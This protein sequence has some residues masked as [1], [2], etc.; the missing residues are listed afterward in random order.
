MA[1][2]DSKKLDFLW[3]KII[4][5]AA[6]TDTINK[7]GPNEAIRA[8]VII[9][10]ENV[11]MRSKGITE[12]PPAADTDDVQVRVGS[13]SVYCVP[14]PSVPGKKT[15]ITVYDRLT[16]PMV[17]S[18]RVKNWIPPSFGNAYQPRIYANVIAADNRLNPLTENEEW[19]F[20]FKAGVIHF[21]NELPAIVADT[22]VVEGYRYVGPDGAGSISGI[23]ERK[24]TYSTPVL[25]PDEKYDFEL[26]TGYSAMILNLSVNRPSV[27][28][29]H[30]YSP[31]EDINP[32]RF[33]AVNGFLTDDGSYISEARRFY[34]PRFVYIHNLEDN[35]S[36]RTYWRIRNTG[37][38]SSSITMDAT[39]L[40]I[41]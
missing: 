14:D 10:G 20:D 41:L 38:S 23:E 30:S 34:G 33:I 31:R 35:M 28:E 6:T 24:I 39:F 12:A 21:P 15:W 3:K 4:Y 36:R 16:S 13:R 37:T 2:S 8:G 26:E 27:V 32:Y 11:W 17:E 1:I 25:A 9:P 29:C 40:K 18:N 19:V 5:G 7:E 22:L